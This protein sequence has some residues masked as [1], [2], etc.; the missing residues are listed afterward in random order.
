ML[1]EKRLFLLDIDGTVCR[2]EQL[3]AGTKEFLE[4]IR[5]CGGQFVFLTNNASKS[6]WDYQSFFQDMGIPTDYSNFM[7]AA[8]AAVRYLKK[9]HRDGLI[10]VLGNRPFIREL[11][12]GGIRVTTDWED[13]EITCAIVSYDNQL[14]YEKIS[15][16]CR[17]LLERQVDYVATNPDYVCPTEFGSVPDCGSICQM[18]E[19][20]V[21]RTPRFLG[22]PEPA[23]VEYAL[24]QSLFGRKETLLVGDRLYTDIACGRRAG[25]ETALVLTGEATRKDAAAGP[26]RPDFLFS[27]I[28]EL[29][30][31]WREEQ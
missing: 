2:G 21:K 23:M 10:Y 25:V 17:L 31:R 15:D 14:T 4:D 26:E 3:I 5:V 22:K 30:S 29:H 18:L 13:A 16:T 20:A 6:V 24:R 8:C 12:R 28:R 19:H 27:S 11:K 9:N 1:K 7:T